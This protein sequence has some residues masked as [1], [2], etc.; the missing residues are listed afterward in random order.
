MR[1][2]LKYPI[3]PNTKIDWKPKAVEHIARHYV[4]PYEVEG[5]INENDPKL[6]GK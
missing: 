6:Y 3:N 4:K 2:K 5:G 1:M